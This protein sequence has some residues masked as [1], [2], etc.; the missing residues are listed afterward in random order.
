MRRDNSHDKTHNIIVMQLQ[1]NSI[2]S[3]ESLYEAA[4]VLY[5]KAVFFP[6]KAKVKS[7]DDATLYDYG[8]RF[9]SVI[10]EVHKKL[11]KQEYLFGPLLEKQVKLGDKNRKL[12]IETWEDK[13][14]ETMLYRLLDRKLNNYLYPKSYAF[15]QRGSK[16]VLKCVRKVAKI[17]QEQEVPFYVLRRDVSNFFPSINREILKKQL[18]EH[19]DPNDY[20]F[21]LLVSRIDFLAVTDTEIRDSNIGVSFGTPLACL[22]GNI[23]LTKLDYEL[24]QLTPFVVR[25]ADDFLVITRDREKALRA[26]RIFEEQWKQLDVTSKPSHQQDLCYKGR[27]DK[28]FSHVREIE[29]LGL[30]FDEKIKL[31]RG[32]LNKVKRIFRKKIDRV[33]KGKAVRLSKKQ[34]AYRAVKACKELWES[35]R[36]LSSRL[37][38]N[39]TLGLI[40]DEEQLQ[41][42]DRWCYEYIMH[43]ATF[44]QRFCKQNFKNASLKELRQVGLPSFLHECRLMRRGVKESLW[45]ILQS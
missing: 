10:R 41:N 3:R 4:F 26:R 42:L 37:L 20:L 14:V 6:R 12:Y 13:L 27:A 24:R 38:L 35:P 18:A 15:R 34:R 36:H 16:G 17:I 40:T 33:L 5:N 44:Y 11:C 30:R 1:F 22:F 32:K 29:Y 25:Y 43:A 39:Y 2:Y 28:V 21:K 23:Y 31:D 45:Q 8:I 7:Y 19:I 9:Q